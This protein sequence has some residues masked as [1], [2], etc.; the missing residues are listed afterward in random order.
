MTEF[1]SR[2]FEEAFSMH[3]SGPVAECECGKTYWDSYNSGYSWGDGERESLETGRAIA[4]P[5]G[6]ERLMIDG[7]IYCMD[8]TCW[9]AKAE[10]I[11]NW[12][13]DNRLQVNEWYR[14]EMKR[15]RHL[16]KE[17]QP[18]ESEPQP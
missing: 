3:V 8:C 11:A 5:H 10:R 13:A 4:V 18:Y 6:V 7:V 1:D 16:A 9:H 17:M 2:Q 12:L 14:L 15:L